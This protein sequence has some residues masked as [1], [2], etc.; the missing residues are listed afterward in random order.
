MK[1]LYLVIVLSV[2]SQIV[3]AQSYQHEAKAIQKLLETEGKTW[4]SGDVQAHAN[5]WSIKP[6]SRIIVSTTEGKT[7]DIDPYTMLHPP[8]EWVG[9]GGSAIHQNYKFN[10]QKNIAWVSHDEVS[11]SSDGIKSYS[12]EIRLLEK[13]K[14]KWKLIGQSIHFYQPQ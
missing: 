8:L 4:R 14:G 1:K 6:Y 2:L 3:W 12:Y 7:M 13:I 9:K 10:I 5:C 11:T